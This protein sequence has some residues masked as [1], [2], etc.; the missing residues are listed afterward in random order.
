MSKSKC[1]RSLY[2]SFLEVTSSRFSA[3]SLSEV[4]PENMALS[5]DSISRWLSSAKVQPKDLWEVASKK[6]ETL[7][8]NQ[9]GILV[10]DDVVINKSRSNKMELVNWQY[11]GSDK[12]V[13][14]GIGVVNALWQTSKEDYTPIDYRIWNP[15]D[16]GKPKMITLGICCLPLK[17]AVLSRKWL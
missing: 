11:S 15:P 10:F 7:P 17:V 3:L 8:K 6:L 16:D 4:A 1:S 5:H 9:G 14:K 12:G 13:V 2:C